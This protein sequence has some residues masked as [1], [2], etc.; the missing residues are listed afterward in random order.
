MKRVLVC[1][2]SAAAL[3]VLSGVLWVRPDLIFE[4]YMALHRVE[5][6]GGSVG[7]MWVPAHVGV[8]GNEMVDRAAKRALEQ[9]EVGV[10]VDLGVFLNGG[11]GYEE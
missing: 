9:D 5:C 6:A 11:V 3:E 8:D 4:L 1:S 10:R 7:F 2:D